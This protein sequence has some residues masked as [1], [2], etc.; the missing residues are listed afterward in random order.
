VSSSASGAVPPTSGRGRP[1]VVPAVSVLPPVLVA[2]AGLPGAGKSAIADDL[3]TRIPAAV[4]SVDPIESAILAAG[5]DAGQPTGLAAYLVAERMAESVLRAGASV[6]VDAV[7][8]VDPARRQW[9]NLGARAGVPVLFVEVVCSDDAVHRRRIEARRRDLPGMRELDWGDVLASR[10]GY[11]DWAGE[12]AAA[13]R[14]TV[15]SVR[16]V[17]DLLADVLSRLTA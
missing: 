16:P 1:V 17:D 4:V 3:G 15:D 11:E 13:A 12:S 7:N 5:V 9:L 8:G 6:V 14:V 2:M 10:D